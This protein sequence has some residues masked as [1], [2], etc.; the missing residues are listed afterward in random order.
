MKPEDGTSPTLAPDQEPVGQDG[1]PAPRRRSVRV[2]G[3]IAI[4]MLVCII[5]GSILIIK[6]GSSSSSSPQAVAV[7]TSAAVVLPKPWCAAPVGLSSSFTGTSISGLSQ[8]DVWSIGVQVMHWTGESWSA[9]YTPPSQ[10]QSQYT[11]R[12]I[13]EITPQNV[14]VV[15]ELQT[16]GLASHPLTLHWDGS[17]WTVINAPDAV[18]GG[19]NALTSLSGI[20]ASDVWAVGFDV[21]SQAPIGAF[22]EHWDGTKWSASRP[23]DIPS[24]AQFTSVKAL[25]ANDVW[26]VGS[27]SVQ[28]AG[29]NLLQPLTEH[30]NGSTW[31]N[32][33]TPSLISTGTASLYSISGSSASDLWTVGSLNSGMLS[34]HWDGT[35]WAVIT[36][37]AVTTSGSNWLASVASL[38]PDDV[39]SVGRVGSGTTGFQPYIEHWDGTKWTV[40]QDPTP[41]AGELDAVTAIGGRYWIVGIPNSSGGHPF[42]ETICP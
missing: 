6:S 42:I 27:V 29:K 33:A 34:E 16:G 31:T 26:A 4:L 10:S 22:V 30:W 1:A 41:G 40:E 20:S 28:S 19:K 21:P 24:G 9:V 18:A 23:S 38:G 8:D 17:S 13:D 39:W 3:I 2:Q 37:P 32:V 7:S 5:A 15:G 12:S 35:K 25:A 11:L 14:W 36:S